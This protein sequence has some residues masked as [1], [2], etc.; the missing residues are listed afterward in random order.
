MSN[1]RAREASRA[2]PEEVPVALVYNGT[3]QAVMMATPSDL[4]D[5]GR[6]FTRTEGLREV[7]SIEVVTH[8]KGIEVQM[9]LPDAQAEALA[10][11]RRAMAGPVGCGLCGI[12]SLE[13]ADRA[14]PKVTA[15]L[16]LTAP[17]I[18]KAMADLRAGQA[19]HDRTRAVHGAGFF[20]PDQG[21]V[22]VREDVGRH[23]ALDKLIGA[24]ADTTVGA[25]VLTS[26][27]SIEMVQKAAMAGA[28]VILAVS[29]PTTL[30]VETAEA[31]N[32][33]LVAL[34][35]ADTF[36]IFAHPHRIHTEDATDVA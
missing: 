20:E 34:A 22:T 18:A 36:E 16:T 7:V 4:E 6:G 1:G 10:S 9:W 5:F 25:I 15:E 29:A 3:T 19:L 23:N 11:R 21:L 2:L 24:V 35:R 32:I 31:A 30:A 14:V 27:V 26:R 8:P 13:E 17:Q 33:T 12:D 28:P